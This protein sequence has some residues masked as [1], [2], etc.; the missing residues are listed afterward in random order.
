MKCG[1]DVS[2]HA[3]GSV[4]ARE[5]NVAAAERFKKVT[6]EKVVDETLAFGSPDTVT[7]YPPGA[8]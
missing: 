5:L 8:A 2:R 1:D 6:W 4:R 3:S 7:T